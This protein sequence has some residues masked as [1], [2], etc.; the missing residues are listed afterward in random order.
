[1]VSEGVFCYS[2]WGFCLYPHSGTAGERVIWGVADHT[3]AV[4][5]HL[6]GVLVGLVGL[7]RDDGVTLAGLLVGPDHMLVDVDDAFHRSCATSSRSR[8][9]AQLLFSSGQRAARLRWRESCRPCR[10]DP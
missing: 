1:M 2:D 4:D 8:P 6:M 10:T 3:R 5:S 9:T 7:Y